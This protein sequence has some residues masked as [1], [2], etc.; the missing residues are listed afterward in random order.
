[1][2][3]TRLDFDNAAVANAANPSVFGHHHGKHMEYTCK[4]YANTGEGPIPNPNAGWIP[5]S[6]LRGHI[7]YIC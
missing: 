5:A 1:M 6:K 3:L 4:A 7:H 2:P